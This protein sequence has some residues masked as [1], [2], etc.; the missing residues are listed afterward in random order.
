MSTQADA[1]KHCLNCR[2]TLSDEAF[3]PRCGQNTSTRR[4]TTK[5]FITEVLTGLLRVNKG[6]IFTATRLTVAPWSVIRNYINGRRVRYTGPV[7]TLLILCFILLIINYFRGSEN[8]VDNIDEIKFITGNETVAAIIKEIFHLFISTPA[9]QYILLFIPAL[10]ILRLVYR[11]FGAS[12]YN[13][14]EYLLAGLYMSD[15]L[16]CGKV[17]TSPLSFFDIEAASIA[18]TVYFIFIASKSILKA[19]HSETMTPLRSAR[20]LITYI[21]LTLT[22]YFTVTLLI[23]IIITLIVTG[24]R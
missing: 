9:L 13:T 15:T 4:L 7:Q 20:L 8:S 5:F 18:T 23:A 19:F 14:A 16:L 21:L 22:V 6:F 3:C 17:I 11:N 10:P 2:H 1:G 12:R 24:V